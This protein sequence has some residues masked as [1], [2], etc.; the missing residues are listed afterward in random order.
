MSTYVLIHG[1]CHRGDCWDQVIHHLEQ[2]GHRAYAPTVGGNEP[3]GNKYITY[4]DAIEHVISYIKERDLQNIILLGHSLGGT[5]I[6]QIA[7]K[8]PDR[9]K[10]L[11][12]LGGAVSLHEKSIAESLDGV[13]NLAAL[14]PDIVF[15][16]P[17]EIQFP[18]WRD[19]F[20]NDG[21]LDTAKKAYETLTSNPT[22]VFME[23]LD[24]AKFYALH[25]PKTYLHG[26]VDTVVPYP[27]YEKMAGR[28]GLHRFLQ[29]EGSH[30]P[31]FSMPKELAEKI[32]QAGQD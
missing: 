6:Q 14:L 2:Q 10:R 32:I 17:F 7:Q 15:G 27:A 19:V 16:E 18:I 30:E 24:L 21:D 22:T 20:I 8:I 4:D 3:N 12:F 29:F 23:K 31:M 11:I 26:S 1:A 13:V 5:H 28:L 25:I 9:I